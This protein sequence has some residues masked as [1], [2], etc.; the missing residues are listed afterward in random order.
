MKTSRPEKALA[1]ITDAMQA[2]LNEPRIGDDPDLIVSAFRR[3]A[4]HLESTT[5][6]DGTLTQLFEDVATR[7]ELGVRSDWHE[8]DEQ[9]VTAKVHGTG[10]EKQGMSG[11]DNDSTRYDS[12]AMAADIADAIGEAINAEISETYSRSY[13]HAFNLVTPRGLKFTVT[14]TQEENPS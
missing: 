8:P 7:I 4:D 12:E 14:V 2:F 9:G 11:N 6:D 3:I 1:I 10:L 5:D 13:G